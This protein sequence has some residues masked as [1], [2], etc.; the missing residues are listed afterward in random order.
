MSESPIRYG[1]SRGVVICSSE[2]A[3][4]RGGQIVAGADSLC[5]R[6]RYRVRFDCS[7]LFCWQAFC[8]GKRLCRAQRHARRHTGVTWRC[9]RPK[10]KRSKKRRTISAA[11]STMGRSHAPYPCQPAC[12]RGHRPA[13]GRSPGNSHPEKRGGTSARNPCERVDDRQP[14]RGSAAAR[15]GPAA[16]SSSRI[17]RRLGAAHATII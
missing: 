10:Q 16:P 3:V 8:I 5:S 12:R 17:E 15:M 6:M 13:Q 1:R 11:N 2:H 14:R 4:Q 7:G 9:E